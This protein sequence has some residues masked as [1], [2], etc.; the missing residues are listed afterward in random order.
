MS[1]YPF[2]RNNAP[3]WLWSR[4]PEGTRRCFANPLNT[5]YYGYF[6]GWTRDENGLLC[7]VIEMEDGQ[8]KIE[9]R[10]YT[11]DFLE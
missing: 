9:D 1:N 8:L 2:A 3:S 11:M 7:A 10:L 5:L 6:H 4:K